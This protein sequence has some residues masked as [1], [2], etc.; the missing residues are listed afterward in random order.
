MAARTP[1]AGDRPLLTIIGKAAIVTESGDCEFGVD[2][3][4]AGNTGIFV[5]RG[6]VEFRVTGRRDECPLV[7]EEKN[8]ALVELDKGHISTIQITKLGARTPEFAWV[9]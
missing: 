1:R 4:K 7:V 9:A 6:R 8:W 3:N 2:V 5:Q